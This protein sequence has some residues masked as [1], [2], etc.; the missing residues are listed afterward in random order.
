[1][2][3]HIS[4]GRRR[5]GVPRLPSRPALRSFVVIAVATG[6]ALVGAG[7]SAADV[8]EPAPV[9]EV[10]VTETPAAE[11]PAETPAAERPAE[12]PEAE[13]PAADPVEAG[14]DVVDS[15]ELDVVPLLPDPD[16][17]SV[18]GTRIGSIIDG[19][20]IGSDTDGTRIGSDTDGTRIG[21]NTDGTRIG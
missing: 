18:D 1:M 6:F 7:V 15:A 19:T 12:T 5:R 10:L 2:D 3:R 16:V 21:S 8:T 13:L 11:G 17:D 4:S 9:T 14:G 20:R